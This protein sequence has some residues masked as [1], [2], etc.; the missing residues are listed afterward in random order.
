MPSFLNKRISLVIMLWLA[1]S[2]GLIAS[3]VGDLFAAPQATKQESKARFQQFLVLHSESLVVP[4]ELL[5]NEEAQ[6]SISGTGSFATMQCHAPAGTARASYH[7][8]TALVVD[9][10][11]NAYVIAC[12]ASLINLRCRKFSPG[13]AINGGID[14]AEKFVDIGNI[15]KFHRLD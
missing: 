10:N 15:Q 14:S 13:I 1:G 8:V 2:T 9:M 4:F 12:H 7:F 11:G 6:C 5:T 3:A